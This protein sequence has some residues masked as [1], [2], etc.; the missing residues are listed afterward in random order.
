MS[1]RRPHTRRFQEFA[2]SI[3]SREV[4]DLARALP[5][6]ETEELARILT[7]MPADETSVR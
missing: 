5:W 1:I 7:A 6:L 3:G 4:A 2:S